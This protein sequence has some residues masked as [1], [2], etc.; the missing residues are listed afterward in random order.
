MVDIDNSTRYI[1]YDK[2]LAMVSL[3]SHTIQ[4][5]LILFHMLNYLYDRTHYSFV[6]DLSLHIYD[7]GM[8]SDIRQFFSLALEVK[9]VSKYE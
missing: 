9:E 2:D 4:I 5:I 3:R 8:I 7:S 6:L 1:Y